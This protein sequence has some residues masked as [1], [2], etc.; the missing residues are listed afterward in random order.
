MSSVSKMLPWK[1]LLN[2]PAVHECLLQ[3]LC[4]D[5]GPK[6][7][8][9]QY[10]VIKKK[11]KKVKISETFERN[12]NEPFQTSLEPMFDSLKREDILVTSLHLLI[13]SQ[14]PFR[15]TRKASVHRGYCVDYL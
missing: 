8:T 3:P 2:V 4:L 1:P 7:V 15:H 11:K 12:A 14:I 5:I 13:L 10:V 6:H 9:L